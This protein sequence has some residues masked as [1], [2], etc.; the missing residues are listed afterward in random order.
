MGNNVTV[1]VGQI[2]CEL[3]NVAGNLRHCIQALDQAA[4]QGISLLVLPECALS[5]YVFD[6]LESARLA[7]VPLSG[8]EIAE[9]ADLCMRLGLYCVVGFLEDDD[10]TVYNTA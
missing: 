7:A 9:L 1:G 10:G 3:A 2:R 6:N 5:G 8:P 4:E